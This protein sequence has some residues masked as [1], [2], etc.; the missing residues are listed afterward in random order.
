MSCK[1][2]SLASWPT[3]SLIRPAAR[4]SK[5]WSS[6]RI[7][8]SAGSGEKRFARRSIATP[9]SRRGSTRSANCPRT[10]W[11]TP[12]GMIVATTGSLF[13]EPNGLPQSAIDD[14]MTHVLAGYANIQAG[15]TCIGDTAR[16]KAG[17]PVVGAAAVEPDLRHRGQP[18][19]QPAAEADRHPRG[20]EGF[21][22]A[23]QSSRG[24]RAGL[25][26]NLWPLM[27][28]PTDKARVRLAIT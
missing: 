14:D 5:I 20:A 12:I 27:P 11:G 26:G 18:H 28:L 15:E 13:S 7:A 24:G 17:Q 9:S 8:I 21:G 22:R 2:C 3:A 25:T 6:T 10:R 16:Y 23:H 1:R 19:A 4:V